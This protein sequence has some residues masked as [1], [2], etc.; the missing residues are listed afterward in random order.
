MLGVA[1]AAEDEKPAAPPAATAP[2]P[3]AAPAAPATTAPAATAPATPAAKPAAEPAKAAPAVPAGPAVVTI[4]DE[5]IDAPPTAIEAGEL[6]IGAE[7]P[8]RMAMDE[9]AAVYLGNAAVL[10]AVWIG[11]DN[12]DV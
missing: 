10:S 4:Y 9:I 1:G 5:R 2:A 3:V 8:R 6:V 11:Q 7:P 12:R